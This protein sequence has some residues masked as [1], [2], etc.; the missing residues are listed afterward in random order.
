[1]LLS[2]S[3]YSLNFLISNNQIKNLNDLTS[4][5]LSSAPFQPAT[6][7]APNKKLMILI[8]G[9]GSLFFGLFV[10]LLNIA[11]TKQPKK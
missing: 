3:K 7:L 5:A 8:A 9:I 10:A 6:P 11:V 2:Q 1:M 4:Y